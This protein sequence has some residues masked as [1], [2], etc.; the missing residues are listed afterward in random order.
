MDS[1]E[2]VDQRDLLFNVT[3]AYREIFRPYRGAHGILDSNLWFKKL[4]VDYAL[5]VILAN[6]AF[7]NLTCERILE[8]STTSQDSDEDS[9]SEIMADYDM[10]YAL[11]EDCAEITR[12]AKQEEIDVRL[13]L[14]LELFYAHVQYFNISNTGGRHGW[15]DVN[16]RLLGS[17]VRLIQLEPQLKDLLEQWALD[18]EDLEPEDLE[19]DST[20]VQA[21]WK[22][23]FIDGIYE[24]ISRSDNSEY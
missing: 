14:S 15:F 12:F 18:I 6:F 4:E 17:M 10:G 21:K 3:M 24:S 16:K 19:D 1:S 22:K 7:V 9:Q 2:S 20:P 5:E 11:S 23:E 13:S 8:E